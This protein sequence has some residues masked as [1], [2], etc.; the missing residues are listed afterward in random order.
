MRVRHGG[1][2]VGSAR[3]RL[4][5]WGLASLVAVAV[6]WGSAQGAVPVGAVGAR[7][8]AG[9]LNLA[10]VA[11]VATVGG[12]PVVAAAGDI[13]CDPLNSS[14]NGGAG[15][16][17][18]CHAKQVSDLLVNAGLSAVLDLGDVQY[19][20]GGYQAFL[21]SYDKSWGRV[22]SITMPSVGNHEYITSPAADRTGCDASNTGA[23]GYY[24]YFGAAAG[25]PGQGYY[26][27]DIGTWHAIVLNSSCSGAGG[28]S[29]TTTQGKWL[30][31]DLAAHKNYCTL[32]YWHIPLYSSGGRAAATYKTFWDALYAADADLVLAGHDH[33]YERFAPQDPNGVKDTSRGLREF[34]VGTGGAN[35]TSFTTIFPNSEVRNSDTF[36]VL[37]LTLHPTSYDWQFVPEA[38]KT[39]TDSGTTSCHGTQKPPPP[40]TPPPTPT[41]A[42]PP[43]SPASPPPPT[44]GSPGGTVPAR[45]T[46]LLSSRLQVQ[47]RTAV[48]GSLDQDCASAG[49]DT[50]R[51]DIRQRGDG[52]VASFSFGRGSRSSTWK[53]TD[54]TPLGTYDVVPRGA[55]DQDTAGTPKAVP[56]NTL[57]ASLRL[58]SWLTLAARRSGSHVVLHGRA[59]RWSR[60]ADAARPWRHQAVRFWVS[61]CQG[62][63]SHEI[64]TRKTDGTGRFSFRVYSPKVQHWSARTDDRRSTWGARPSGSRGEPIA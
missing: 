50:A 12:D 23:A 49:T 46:L 3:G 17:S 2:R 18:S 13:A 1:T 63:V 7:P 16:S 24:K 61:S 21:N 4:S 31:A 11:T 19:Y 62:C 43:A 38:G 54:A 5:R 22:K 56:Q 6:V 60:S 9:I 27:F 29:P 10:P 51:W 15:S 37:K 35:H 41:P 58:R 33:T 26:S 36:G 52:S 55:F 14:F 8:V 40:T 20:C 39:F 64:K 45:C 42:T 30:R 25:Q 48:T 34:V 59:T 32:A 44:P 53:V 47:S 57:T 28:C